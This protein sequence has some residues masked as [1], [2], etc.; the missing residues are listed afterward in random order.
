[1]DGW[2]Q[3]GGSVHRNSREGDGAR[4]YFA[5]G[6]GEGESELREPRI[7]SEEEEEEET[8]R[9]RFRIVVML[10]YLSRRSVRG[11]VRMRIRA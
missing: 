4:W 11:G 9:A 8:V 10:F 7:G 5:A 6:S 3:D 2:L 1:V